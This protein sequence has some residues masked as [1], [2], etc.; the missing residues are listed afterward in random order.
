M[1]IRDKSKT[2]TKRTLILLTP[3]QKA[4][5]YKRARNEG[6]HVSDYIRK[7]LFPSTESQG[8]AE[9]LSELEFRV[10]A[11]EQATKTETPTH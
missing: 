2:Y 8:L 3:E 10:A 5:L 7:A 1:H 11:L 6:M 4:D 9:R